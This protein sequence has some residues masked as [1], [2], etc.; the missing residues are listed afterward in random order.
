M[1]SILPQTKRS[2]HDCS[3]DET[4]PILVYR[5]LAQVFAAIL[6][7]VASLSLRRRPRLS[8]GGVPVDCQYSASFLK[9]YSYQWCY[10]LLRLAQL[11]GRLDLEDLPTL[12]YSASSQSLREHFQHVLDKY[13]LP[14]W[15]TVFVAHWSAFLQQYALS[16]LQSAA[17]LAPQFAMYSLLKELEG[18]GREDPTGTAGLSWAIGLGLSMIVSAW[19]ETQSLWMVWSRLTICVRTELIAVIYMKAMRSKDVKSVPTKGVQSLKLSQHD[20]S[21]ISSEMSNDDSEGTLL[22]SENGENDNDVDLVRQLRLSIINLVG[23]D[24]KRVTE[25]VGISH[26][27]PSS[28]FKLII[29]ITFLNALIG[30]ESVL[31]GLAVLVVFTPF[32]LYFSNIMNKAQRQIMR[33]RDEKMAIINEALHGIRQI[34]FVASERQW[35]ERIRAKRNEELRWQWYS[36]LLRTALVGV[37]ALG[38]VMISAV[39]LSV[40]TLLQGSLS[41]SVAFTSIA[42]LGQIESSLAIIPK[43]IMET[44]EAGISAARIGQYLAERETVSYTEVADTVVFRNASI[45]WPTDLAQRTIG[46]SLQAINVSFPP[47]EL[48]IISGKTGSGKSLL[49]AAIIGEAEKLSG[50]IS[51][52]KPARPRRD[53]DAYLQKWII[54]EAMAFVAQVPWIENASIKDNILFGLPYQ[55][56]RYALTLSV[57]AL[58][59]DLENLPDGDLTDIGAG[60]INLSGGQK[61]R[62]SFSRAIYSRA[63]ILILDDIFSAVDADVGSHLFEQ[64]LCGELGEGRTRILVT[65]HTEF[66]LSKA[67]CHVILGHGGLLQVENSRSPGSRG[68]LVESPTIGGGSIG[69]ESHQ[70]GRRSEDQQ[71]QDLDLSQTISRLEEGFGEPLVGENG[72]AEEERA[73]EAAMPKKFVEDEKRDTGTV[74]VSTYRSYL[75]AAGGL[76]VATVVVVAHLGY[77]ASILSRVRAN[78]FC[79]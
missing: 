77:M 55:E 52:P 73:P 48:S 12:N 44:L 70:H 59:K 68:M 16:M 31:A 5:E 2:S 47:K 37:W 4:N 18:R 72:T 40:H 75:K 43:L 56:K 23:V 35:L 20:G 71:H 38:P 28:V 58:S 63:G 41:P 34:K 49:L 15:K 32:N 42:I 25:F 69:V 60:G 74:R 19:L 62:V 21:S 46:F 61:W 6:S 3:W 39:A 7:I 14:L 66:C 22:A 26:M 9:R 67:S 45:A 53:D 57:C 29:S 13:D 24:T 8:K 36:F 11:K 54:P 10:S 79:L 33:I 78:K 65:H 17:Q 30:W 76:W 1:T 64:A 50:T 51:V 27:L